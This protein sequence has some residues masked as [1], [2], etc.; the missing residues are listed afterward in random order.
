MLTESDIEKMA[1]ESRRTLVS[2]FQE[3]YTSLRTRAFR[4]PVEQASKIADALKCPLQV[5]TIAYLIEMDGIM[6]AKRA[7]DLMAVELQR[8]ASI[9]EEIP[10]IPSHILEFSINEGKWIEY[11]YGRFARDVEQKTRSLVNLEGALDTEAA[12]VEQ[13][14]AVLRERARVAEGSIAPVV[15]A[16][17]KEHPRAT[18][19]DALLAFGPALTKWPRNT[20]LGRLSVARRRN[21]AFFRLLNKILSTASDSATVD[22]TIR[23]VSAL[24]DDLSSELATLSPT[25]VSHLLLHVTPRPIGR[26]DRSPYVSVGAASYRGGKIEPDMNSPF[27]FLERDIHL[28]RRRREDEREQYLMERIS[29]VIRV[30]TYKGSPIDDCVAQTLSEIADRF[31]VSKASVETYTEEAKENLQMVPLDQRD[32][33]AARIVYDFVMGHVYNR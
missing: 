6:S 8:R 33:S 13:A 19:L 9:G 25:A 32:E 16:W 20:F 28:A 29:R 12:T 3:K 26:G 7:V 21:Q 14:L 4:V 18:S 1:G 5:A 17:L 10:N 30:L 2:E 15:T 27:D 22:D 24:I 23:R 11:I 31:G